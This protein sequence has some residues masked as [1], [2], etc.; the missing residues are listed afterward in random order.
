MLPDIEGKKVDFEH[1][2]TFPYEEVLYY[3]DGPRLMLQRSEVGQLY[4]TWWSDADDLRERWICLPLSTKRLKEIL[5][6]KIPSLEAL[7]SPEDGYLLVIDV[8]LKSDSV[9]Q[10]LATSSSHVPQES[11]PRP[12]AKLNIPVPG[13]LIDES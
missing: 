7:K 4:L 8:D 5:S 6:G 3:Y 9:V 1:W 2:A 10:A 11:L 13:S 12:G